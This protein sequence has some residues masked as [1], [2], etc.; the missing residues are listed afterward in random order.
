MESVARTSG[1]SML[2]LIRDRSLVSHIPISAEDVRPG[3]V[4]VFRL[5]DRLVAHRVIGRKSEE[6][7]VRFR[8]KGD[9]EFATSWIG[10]DALVGRAVSA[11]RGADQ[12]R[13]DVD[14]DSVRVRALV[15]GARLEA[16]LFAGYLRLR[17]AAPWIRWPAIALALPV[18][19][20]RWAFYRVLLTV[21]SRSRRPETGEE[22]AFLLRC[23]RGALAPAEPAAVAVQDWTA[24][25]EA[26]GA[27][28]LAPLALK[29]L[30][31]DAP[32]AVFD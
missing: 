32:P 6:G 9:H 13:L 8:Q 14:P 30:A 28:R 3:D 25:L 7:R 15:A 4:I 23:F 24:V 16:A 5:A 18:A 20:F 17:N 29:Q 31:A 22:Q 10:A 2:P 26:V 27:H 19:P 1:R 11:R 12:R 21:Y